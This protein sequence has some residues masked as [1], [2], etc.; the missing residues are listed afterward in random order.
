MTLQEAIVAAGYEPESYSGRG[1]FGRECLAY[2]VQPH[3]MLA[4]LM[5]VGKRTDADDMPAEY[6]IRYDSLGNN[7]IV[8]FLDHEYERVE[9][10]AQ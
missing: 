5:L 8:Y 2:K 6:S 10:S 9:S 7:Q 1:M 4:S 3:E